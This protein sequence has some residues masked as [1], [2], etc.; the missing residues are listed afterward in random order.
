MDVPRLEPLFKIKIDLETPQLVGRG[1]LG[2][3]SIHYI[4]GGT[5]EGEKIAGAVLP[6]GG[7]WLL[8][9]PDGFGEVDVRLTLRT[10]DDA[11]VYMSYP[12]LLSNVAEITASL[13]AG[14]RVEPGSFYF[15]TTPRFETGS[16]RYSWLNEL[17]AI[18]RGQP[19]ATGVEYD[20]FAAR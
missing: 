3:R 16:E 9:R 17:V 19:T 18:G 14:K 8:V 12:G 10:G 13:A 15:Y 4:S 5:F 7:D 1:P 11:L 2:A 20:V 6:G